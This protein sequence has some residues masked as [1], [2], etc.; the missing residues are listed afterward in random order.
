LA[1]RAARRAGDFAKAEGYLH[2]DRKSPGKETDETILEWALCRAAGGDLGLTEEYLLRRARQEPALAPLIWEALIEGYLRM[3]RIRDALTCLDRWLTLEPD[4]FLP[5]FLRGKLHRQVRAFA[6][7]VTDYRRVLELAPQQKEARWFLALALYEAG[8]YEEAV[9]LFE[10]IQPQ[11][12][13]DPELL[14][15]LAR[16]FEKLER[17]AAAQPLLDAVLAV[18]PNHPLALRTCGQM[19]QA[20]GDFTDA[21]QWLNRAAQAAP[22]DYQA[23]WALAQCWQQM[24][25]AAQARAQQARAEALKQRFERLADLSVH[26]M[27]ARPNDPA[28]HCEMGLILL[29]LGKV[30]LGERWLKS[31]L[32]QKGDYGPAQA[33]LADLYQQRGDTATAQAYRNL[34]RGA[35]APTVP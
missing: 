7:A 22:Y 3:F 8:R 32:L 19:A 4:N 17:P 23:Q 35:K 9:I 20:R 5:H 27:S 11:R 13:N 31:A 25:K 16:C 26:Q 18:E 10:E 21:E 30:E 6:K 1:A 33:A 29:R 15:R 34:A 24:G 2:G 28:L 14:V 12:P